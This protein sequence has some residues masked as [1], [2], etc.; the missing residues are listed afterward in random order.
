MGMSAKKSPLDLSTCKN[1]YS[2]Q[3]L[4]ISVLFTFYYFVSVILLFCVLGHARFLYQ[5]QIF[6]LAL[7]PAG[8]VQCNCLANKEHGSTKRQRDFSAKPVFRQI[9]G[10]PLERWYELQL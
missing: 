5:K 3:L 6:D 2:I 9:C 7:F 1:K 8:Y 4:T 10:R